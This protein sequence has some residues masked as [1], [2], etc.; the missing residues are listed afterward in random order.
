[1][2]IGLKQE[3]EKEG[4]VVDALFDS[5]ATRLVISEEFTRKQRFRRIKLERPIYMRNVDGILNYVEPMVDTVEVE[6]FFKEHKKRM[7]IDVIGGQKWNI[8][9]SMLWLACHNPEIDWR[10]EEVQMM[11]CP[12]ECGK[13][14]RIGKQM[15]SRWQK[16]K[17][18]KERGEEFRRPM[19]DKKIAIARIVEKKEEDLIELRTVEKMVPRQFHKYLKVFKKKESERMPMKKAWNHAIDLREGFVPKKGKIYLLSRVEREKV[20]EFVKNQLRKRYI[21][22]SKLPQTLLVFFVP[23]KD[24]KKR[25]V[26]DY[27]YLNSWTIKNNYPLPLISDLINSIGKKKVFT[28]M[29]L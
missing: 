29:D 26:Q 2:K 19:I 3:E 25:M 23:K 21:R 8:I 20:Q 13:K 6:I 15:K 9:L 14:W 11:R 7:L 12:E 5:G 1:M 17:E 28:K 4:I 24:G 10:M 27:R 16:Q 22:P 18:K